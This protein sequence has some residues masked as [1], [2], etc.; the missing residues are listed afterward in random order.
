MGSRRSCSGGRVSGDDPAGAATA[1]GAGGSRRPVRRKK[2]LRAARRRSCGSDDWEDLPPPSF[3]QQAIESAS[4]ELPT[5]EAWSGPA[6]EVELPRRPLG[7]NGKR[8]G[9][10][11]VKP[12]EVRLAFSPHER[13]L[14]LDTWQRSGLP[15]GD[16][17][18]LVGLSKHTLYLWKKRFAAA[19]TGRSDG[20]AAGRLDGQQAVGG[21]Q[22]HDRDAQAVASRTGAA[23]GSATSC[24]AA[25]RWRPVP[26]A[27]ARVLHEAGYQL[28]ER[29]TRPHPDKVRRFERAR[30]N[31]LWQTD[32]FTFVLKRQNRRL[33][34]VGFMDDHSRFMVGYGLHA[35]ASARLVLEVLRAAI[36][37]YGPAGGDPHRQR[38]AV[39]HLARQEPVQQGTGAARDS[40]GGL[41]P[42]ASADAGQDRAVLGDA[43]AGVSAAGGVPGPGRCAAADRFVH[44]PLQLPTS[45]PRVGGTDAGR[46]VLSGGADGAG[47]AQASGWRPTPWNWRGKARRGR[48]FT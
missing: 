14:I 39:R 28:E 44:R 13:L 31:Q 38:S 6:S 21:D 43:V 3:R 2:F 7:W 15:A 27:V 30:P 1:C 4:A 5:D 24:S 35:S 12:D 19:R 41:A 25:R 36:A 34:L 45:A 37:S 42:Q 22:A 17:A 46:S 32:L 20:A 29:V 18:P 10:R 11:L 8:K 47:N 9:R 26:A 16:F 33:Y 23:S 40:P 48:R